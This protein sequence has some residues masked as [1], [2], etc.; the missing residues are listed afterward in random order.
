MLALQF[1]V[2]AHAFSINSCQQDTLNIPGVKPVK[3]GGRGDGSGGGR[4][5]G[6]KRNRQL[7]EKIADS[8]S[9]ILIDS[10]TAS[11]NMQP[12]TK[13]DTA[14]VSQLL[15]LAMTFDNIA[16]DSAIL[17]A[18]ESLKK[19]QDIGFERGEI[20]ARVLLNTFYSEAAM[21]KE[22][23]SNGNEL[24]ALAENQSDFSRSTLYASLAKF[25]QIV[26][27]TKE[28][29]NYWSLALGS[30]STE[31]DTIN[32][33]ATYIDAANYRDGIGE[34][35]QAI[36]LLEAGLTLSKLIGN[37]VAEHY[38]LGSIG[39]VYVNKGEF[40]TAIDYLNRSL[41]LKKMHY[42]PVSLAYGYYYLQ[43]AYMKQGRFAESI[44]YG[45]ELQKTL[46][47]NPGTYLFKK[48]I[49]A[50]MQASDS[51]G[52][53]PPELIEESDHPMMDALSTHERLMQVRQL[54][55]LH[56][57]K[58]TIDYIYLQRGEIGALEAT[59]VFQEKIILFSVLGLI[60][61]FGSVY[62]VRSR[63]FALKEQKNQ[64][65]FSRQLLNYQED[66]RQRISRDLHDSIGQ[67]LVLIKNKVQLKK[68]EETSTL[69][70]K[71]LEEVQSISKQL[72][73][74][75][76]EKLGLTRSVRKLVDDLDNSTEIF[77]DSDIEDVD[78]LFPI[79]FQLHIYR[80]MQEAINNM[81]KHAETVSA[82]IS[83]E[84]N[85]KVVT[86]S[87][88]DRGKGFDLVES[89]EKFQSLGMQTLKERTKILQGK[90]L[91][92]STKGKGT[93]IILNI[94]ILSSQMG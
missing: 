43:R 14:K 31:K 21:A 83:I 24:L 64:E 18:K 85:E 10:Q 56:N 12:H 27:K 26:G 11:G 50:T 8:I 9:M 72:H 53:A 54:R 79:D 2:T 75:L 51:L 84:K 68:D 47:I 44:Q 5:D 92:D 34:F 86:C 58:K 94:P 41:R 52:L 62:L 73:P 15:R 93:A 1:A 25:Y 67:S 16:I 89:P 40:E 80:I 71:T 20:S 4:G 48:S 36:A 19:S 78:G 32:L 69:I 55:A 81:V 42:R 13:S 38:I 59:T 77:V 76:I 70:A 22:G 61:L 37:Y 63:S 65:A 66:E 35:D 87:V 74:V 82:R 6:A 33:I 3:G 57:D 29:K 28:T 91:I 90:L 17:F 45:E 7:P 30:F 23:I 60:L 46:N 88:I 39:N 49:E